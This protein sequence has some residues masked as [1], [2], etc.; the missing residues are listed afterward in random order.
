MADFL[1]ASTAGT[2][3][4]LSSAPDIFA[5]VE[6][7]RSS[8]LVADRIRA[9]IQAGRIAVGDRLPAE[10]D[11]CERLGVSRVTLREALRILETN[12]LITVKL[13][14]RG[15]AVV[16]VPP[17]GVVQSGIG[18]LLALSALS[19]A[20]I[21]EARTILEL[22]ILPLVCERA[23]AKDIAELLALCDRA[24][25]ERERGDYDVH[26]SLDF[27]LRLAKAAGNPALSLLLSSFEQPLLRSLYVAA[28]S[29]TSGVDEHRQIVDAV[30]ARDGDA[31]TAIMRRHLART[32]TRVAS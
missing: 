31:A 10:R 8:Q 23:D 20:E 32:A 18:D 19:S 30:A 7:Q 16:T 22:G 25:A 28:H 24:R 9:L 29:D 2:T 6:A 11:L 27:H 14:V 12:G 13:G 1:I 5:P 17:V 4:A 21:T 15:G 26:A 3:P